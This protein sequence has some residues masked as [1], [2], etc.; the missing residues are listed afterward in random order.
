MDFT[1]GRVE[2]FEDL[3]AWRKA[4]EL[5]RRVYEVTRRGQFAADRALASQAQRAAVSIMANVAEGFERGRPSEFHQFL[6]V[7]KASCGELR[8]HLYV[9]LDAGYLE[10]AAFGALRQQCEEVGRIVGGLRQSVSGRRSW[11]SRN[12]GGEAKP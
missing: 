7:A 11:T 12:G 8:S 3:V 1:S 10:P 4:R 6:S 9:A 5:T 2:R